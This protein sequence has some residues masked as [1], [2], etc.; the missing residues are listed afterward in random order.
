MD[1]DSKTTAGSFAATNAFPAATATVRDHFEVESARWRGHYTCVDTV[2]HVDL[3]ERLEAASDMLRRALRRVGAPVRILEAGCGTG[4][5]AM[6][7]RQ[8]GGQVCLLD[9]SIG[10]L[11]QARVA[12]PDAVACAADV[13]ALPFA[14]ESFDVVQ[15][16]GVLEYVPDAARAVAELRRVLRPSGHVILSFPNRASWFRRLHACERRATRGIRAALRGTGA[17]R[18]ACAH[19][20]WTLA[21]FRSLLWQ[22][23]LRLRDAAFRTFALRTPALERFRGNVELCRWMNQRCDPRG[24]VAQRLGCTAVVWAEAVGS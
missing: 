13:T 16:L 10:M 7:G 11:R 1:S 17:A 8:L 24:P 15:A 19:R 5:G 6:R 14:P 21:E 23:H 18:P 2:S 20:S 9:L 22:H 4:E 12:V 3:S